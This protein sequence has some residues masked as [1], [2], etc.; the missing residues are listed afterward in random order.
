[1]WVVWPLLSGLICLLIDFLW[2]FGVPGVSWFD[3][4]VQKEVGVLVFLAVLSLA[5]LEV[6]KEVW[7]DFLSCVSFIDFV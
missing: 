7:F 6:G 2:F 1:M 3:L 5:R 4:C